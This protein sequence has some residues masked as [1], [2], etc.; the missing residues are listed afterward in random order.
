[1]L[2]ESLETSLLVDRLFHHHVFFFHLHVLYD[3]E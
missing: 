3:S 2:N 1:M